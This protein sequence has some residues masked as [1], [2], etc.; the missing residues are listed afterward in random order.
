MHNAVDLAREVLDHLVNLEPS[1]PGNF[2]MLSN[3]YAAAGDWDSAANTRL[4]MW[5]R[6]MQKP[7]GASSIEVDDDVHEFTVF[8]SSIKQDIQDDCRTES[9]T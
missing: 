9:G 2:S 7:S 5:S 1:V 8:P 4:R 3:V 6:G